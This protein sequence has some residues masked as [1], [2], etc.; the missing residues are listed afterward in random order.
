MSIGY[1]IQALKHTNSSELRK[2]PPVRPTV[3]PYATNRYRVWKSIS[4]YLPLVL[5]CSPHIHAQS[6]ALQESSSL[7]PVQSLYKSG[8]ELVQ[9]GRLDDAIQTFERGIRV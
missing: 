2:L 9:H 4:L 6:G 8:M 5:A 1:S 3:R 7:P